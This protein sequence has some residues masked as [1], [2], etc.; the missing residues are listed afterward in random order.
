MDEMCTYRCPPDDSRFAVITTGQGGRATANGR[1]EVTMGQQDGGS[2]SAPGDVLGGPDRSEHE[3]EFGAD[4]PGGEDVLGGPDSGESSG[5]L[6]A[7]A[8]A[9]EDELGEDSPGREDVLGG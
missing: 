3:D 4:Q 5:E 9:H 1:L 8:S 6:G 7:D 2:G